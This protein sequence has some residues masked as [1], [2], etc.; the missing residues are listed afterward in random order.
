MPNSNKIVTGI[1]ILLCLLNITGACTERHSYPHSLIT[2]DSLCRVN[3][4]SAVLFLRNI[5][6][7]MYHAEDKDRMYYRL[8]CIQAADKADKMAP[9]DEKKN[10]AEIVYYYENNGDRNILPTAYYYAGRIYAELQEAPIA[11]DY[12]QKANDALKKGED[13]DLSSRIYSQMGYLFY[14]QEIY[15]ES[16]KMFIAAYECNKQT[17]DTIA[18]IYDLRDISTAYEAKNEH[19]K[20]FEYMKDAYSLAKKFKN[21]YMIANIDGYLSNLYEM[22]NQLDSAYKYIQKQINNVGIIDSSSTYSIISDIYDLKGEKDSVLFY[23]KKIETVGNVYAKEDAYRLMTEIY[24]ERGNCAEANRCFKMHRI[25]A[26]SVKAI[27]RTGI[28]AR[29]N[30]MYNY[31]KKEKEN[32]LLNEKN[33]RNKITIIFSSTTAIVLTLTLVLIIMYSR[34]RRKEQLLQYKRSEQLLNDSIRKSKEYINTNKIK[35][36]RLEEQLNMLDKENVELRKEL[37]R[38]K[39]RLFSENAIA[40]MGIKERN[41]AAEAIKSSPIYR[42][43]CKL[44]EKN[45]GKQPSDEDWTKL[46]TLINREYENFTNKLKNLCRLSK[47]ELHASM[48]VKIDIEPGKIS[49]L[50]CCSQSNASTI[51]SR[52]YQKVFGK[53]GGCKEWD[54]FIM[55]L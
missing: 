12:F 21:Q 43:F 31:Q 34:I 3:P 9:K 32:I 7:D 17:N 4:D 44:A 15:D 2:A 46:E 26:D 33:N 11:L 49:A 54:D 16:L 48:L 8:L 27:K 28:I 42:H 1:I 52:L 22:Q 53:K 19:G 41:A 29:I 47:H 50:L 39:E 24:L 23:S 30:A 51:R 25:Y 35:I 55:T 45:S 40:K 38:E 6:S 10:I 37:E 20:A 5:K 14:Y 13:I 18:M 36:D